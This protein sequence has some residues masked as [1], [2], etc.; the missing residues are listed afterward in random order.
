MSETMCILIQ[1]ILN[2]ENKKQL[3][4]TLFLKLILMRQI[5]ERE[6]KI[7]IGMIKMRKLQLETEELN[8]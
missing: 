8:G 3:L 2:A 7:Y 5:S 1:I 6:R 4:N